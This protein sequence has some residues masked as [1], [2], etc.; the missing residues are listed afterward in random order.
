MESS[1]IR[2][3]RLDLIQSRHVISSVAAHTLADLNDEGEL[4]VPDNSGSFLKAR[5]GVVY[6]AKQFV[7]VEESNVTLNGF[8]GIFTEDNGFFIDQS[9]V[10]GYDYERYFNKLRHAHAEE[11]MFTETD[12]KAFEISGEAIVVEEPFIF[13]GSD[14]PSNFGSWI[15]RIIPKLASCD[16]RRYPV[17][18]YQNS[19]WMETMIRTFFGDVVRI[20]KHWPHMTYKAKRAVIPSLRNIDVFFDMDSRSFYR[21]AAARIDGVSEHQRIYLSRRGQTLRP[22]RNEA[23]IEARLESLGFTVIQPETMPLVDQIRVV[24]DAKVIVCPGGSGLFGTVFASSAEFILDIEQST[25]WLYAHHN[26]LRSNGHRHTILFGQ[27]DQDSGP[28]PPWT[29]DVAKV[30]QALRFAGAI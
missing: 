11:M 1:V 21:N 23:E 9:V 2:N 19:P 24:R 25:D 5:I 15:Y 16:Y 12:G 6:Q 22:L 7:T 8:R 26:L 3:P 27:P 13:L 4:L 17:M 18:V 14:E 28:H 20:G 30:E 29:V 10:E